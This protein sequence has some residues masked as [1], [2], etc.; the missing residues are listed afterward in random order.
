MTEHPLRHKDPES[1]PFY[2]PEESRYAQASEAATLIR[3][4]LADD[5]VTLTPK[6]RLTLTTTLGILGDI[7]K[8]SAPQ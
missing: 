5:A 1:K 8:N 7:M 3:R 4:L 6:N 2:T